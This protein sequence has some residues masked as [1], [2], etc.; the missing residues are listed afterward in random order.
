MLIERIQ[1]E[2]GHRYSRGAI[3]AVENG[4]RGASVELIEAIEIAYGLPAG[5]IRVDYKARSLGCGRDLDG[6][7]DE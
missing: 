5:S 2:T 7:S 4:H 3:S 1:Q 6:Q